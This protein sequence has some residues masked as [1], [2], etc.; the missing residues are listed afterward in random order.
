M[1]PTTNLNDNLV[2]IDNLVN[3][4]NYIFEEIETRKKE[5][6][7]QESLEKGIQQSVS[8]QLKS[9][10]FINRLTREI[11]DNYWWDMVRNMKDE[12]EPM[13]RVMVE[14]NLKVMIRRELE[15]LGYTQQEP[16]Q[17]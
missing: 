6:T 15:S 5:I 7:S 10:Q 14:Q 12:L 8:E 4:L 17:N 1:T 2:K 13:I 3:A 16:N 9:Y 11:R